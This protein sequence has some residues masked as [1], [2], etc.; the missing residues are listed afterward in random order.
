[1][2]LPVPL[3]D[4]DAVGVP[5]ADGV[6]VDVADPEGVGVGLVV[7]AGVLVEEVGVGDAPDASAV[8]RVI[9]VLPKS[10]V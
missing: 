8:R 3:G 10:L 9:V 1:M 4:G 2:G 5:L 7:A 6:G